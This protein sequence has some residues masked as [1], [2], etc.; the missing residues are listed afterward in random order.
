[1]SEKPTISRHASPGTGSVNTYCIETANGVV[2]VDGQRQI[3]QAKEV[4][5]AI[6]KTGKT[7]LAILVTHGHPDHYGGLGAFHEAYPDA[8][9]YASADTIAVIRDDPHQY[10]DLAR[11]ALGD[12]FPTQISWPMTP[13]P[14]GGMLQVD[15]LKWVTKEFGPGESESSTIFAIADT[16][17]VF[18]GDIV[19]NGFTP[20]LI[21]GRSSLWLAAIDA[22]SAAFPNSA[23]FHPG[24]GAPAA[25]G[26]LIPAERAAITAMS[27]AVTQAITRN[28]SW[29]DAARTDALAQVAARFD[30]LPVPADIPGLV[31]L[32]LD[33]VAREMAQK[34]TLQ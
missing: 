10:G 7:V 20:F 28:G 5:A 14:E 3:S 2:V 9:I 6:G 25:S 33:A 29:N 24:H 1:M 30:G 17:S 15:G 18:V 13:L 26:E 32:N 22:L 12:D 8:P 27:D 34:E 31:G 23:A 11:T 19:G 16:S 4:I 21:E